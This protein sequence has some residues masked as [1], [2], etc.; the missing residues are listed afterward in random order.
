VFE[1][2]HNNDNCAA[3]PGYSNDG[4]SPSSLLDR[5]KHVKVLFDWK[6]KKRTL[7]VD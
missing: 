7:I 6:Y 2:R 1:I 4:G 3:V 5:E